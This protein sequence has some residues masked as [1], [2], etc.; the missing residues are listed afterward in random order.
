MKIN[1][2]EM[3]D[4][5]FPGEACDA[6]SVLQELRKT[7]GV[8]IIIMQAAEVVAE[9]FRSSISNAYV[10]YFNIFHFLNR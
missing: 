5:H 1:G 8:Q 10:Y 3:C 7:L 9:L 2:K 4:L 6:H